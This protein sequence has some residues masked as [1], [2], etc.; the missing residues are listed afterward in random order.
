MIQGMIGKYV[1]VTN[2]LRGVYYGKLKHYDPSAGFAILEKRRHVHQYE[3]DGNEAGM[4]ALPEVGP[5]PEGS[6]VGVPSSSPVL[7]ASVAQIAPVSEKAQ[8]AFNNC[9]VWT[10]GN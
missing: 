7:I 4:W 1:V 6:Q 3:M 9:P 2:A 5:S 8:V 10:D